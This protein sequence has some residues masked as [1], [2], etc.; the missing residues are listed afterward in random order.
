[1][2]SLAQGPTC[3]KGYESTEWGYGSWC[4]PR[5]QRG[6][7]LSC[8]VQDSAQWEPC[9]HLRGT[10]MHLCLP[11]YF[12]C[13]DYCNHLDEALALPSPWHT[14]SPCQVLRTHLIGALLYRR[15]HCSKL[16]CSVWRMCSC[17]SS[18]SPPCTLTVSLKAPLEPCLA[19]KW[20]TVSPNLL[21]HHPHGPVY[22]KILLLTA[23]SPS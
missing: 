19:V 4:H 2:K 23:L 7:R 16:L 20:A 8:H 12:P 18:L 1:M 14:C 9:L 6:S 5:T 11:H 21:S 3:S 10:A 13:I 15:Q 17:L 22:V